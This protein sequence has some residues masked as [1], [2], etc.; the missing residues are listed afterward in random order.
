MKGDFSRISYQPDAV[1]VLQEKLEEL[2][3]THEGKPHEEVA[4]CYQDL[5]IGLSQQGKLK[6]A[7]DSHEKSLAQRIELNGGGEDASDEHIYKCL[8]LLGNLYVC[9]SLLVC[10]SLQC[11]VNKL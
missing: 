3:K 5:A 8:E 2:Q 4:Q 7:V 10:Y 9:S 1:T 6:Q 11:R